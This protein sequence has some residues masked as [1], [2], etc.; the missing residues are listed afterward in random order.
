MSHPNDELIQRFYTAFAAGDGA[1]MASCYAP[2]VE[3]S[4]PVFGDLRGYRAGAMWQMLTSGPGEAKI[5]LLEHEAN[6]SKGS[7][8]WVADYVF[9]ETGRP[10]HNDIRAQF[11]F[12]NG[13]I[14]EHRDSFDFHRWARQALGPMG[15]LLGWTPIVR[16]AVR[17]KADVKLDEYVGAHPEPPAQH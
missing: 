11:E 10:V 13:L 12:R 16:S 14:A 17:K 1:G 9:S 3:F 5:E 2:D 4:D 15:L 7:A 6:D 8:H